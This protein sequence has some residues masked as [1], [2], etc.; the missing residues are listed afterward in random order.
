MQGEALIALSRFAEAVLVLERASEA[1]ADSPADRLTARMLKADALFAMGA[2]NPVRYEEALLAYHMVGHG[3]VLTPSRRLVIAYK[4]ARTLEKLGRLE[5]ALD[6]YYANVVLAYRTGR[7]AGVI[8]DDDARAVFVKAA[9][10]LANEYERR[11]LKMQAERILELVAASDVPAAA[12][13]ERRI[14]R[15]QTGGFFP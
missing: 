9:F 10:R 1:A 13:A 5:G 14:D 15:L 2:D 12:E 7:L 8:F 3:E 11:G 6:E 4:V